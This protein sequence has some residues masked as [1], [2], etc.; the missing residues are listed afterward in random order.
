MHYL[1]FADT[2]L[3]TVVFAVAAFAKARSA[4]AFRDFA[5]SLR[6][7]GVPAP[8]AGT[9]IA[10]AVVAVEAAVAVLLAWSAALTAAGADGPWRTAPGSAGL[11]AAAALLL[12]FS[13]GI[14]AGLRRGGRTTCQCFGPS[15]TVLGVRHIVRNLLL[16]GLAAAGLPG[17]GGDGHAAGLLVAA[18]AGATAALLVIA[19][20]DIVRLFRADIVSS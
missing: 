13:A 19:S 3:L 15:A 18:C 6:R 9:P 17:T 7:L 16:A 12:A 4:D 8:R 2:V 10:V 20:D 14:G 11:A 1:H 5:R